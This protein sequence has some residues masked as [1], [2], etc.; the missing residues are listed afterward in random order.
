[1]PKDKR[2]YTITIL[3]VYGEIGTVKADNPDW[4]DYLHLVKMD[5][6]RVIERVLYAA[7]RSKN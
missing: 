5:G 3:D 2:T 7:N 4:I 6:E 1:M